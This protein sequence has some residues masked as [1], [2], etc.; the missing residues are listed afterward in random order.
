M[1]DDDHKLEDEQNLKAL[2]VTLANTSAS[3]EHG[4][5]IYETLGRTVRRMRIT[6]WVALIGLVLDFALSLSFALILSN[7]SH[8]NNRISANQDRI[9]AVSCELNTLLVQT[10][11]PQSYAKSQDKKLY[12]AQYH[13][14][15]KNRKTLNCQPVINEPV[16]N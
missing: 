9:T 2:I 5:K 1:E 6:L 10:D 3:L 4:E 16:R 15:Y 14:L 13:T 7:Q 11:T 8:L 12:V